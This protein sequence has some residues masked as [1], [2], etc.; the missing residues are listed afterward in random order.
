M[1]HL[2][3]FGTSHPLQ[4]GDLSVAPSAAQAFETEV[5]T[6]IRLHGIARVAEEMSQEGLEHHGVTE[7]IAARVARELNRE[8][9]HV[10]LTQAERNALGLGDGP[11]ATIRDPYNPSDSGQGFRA[12]TFVFE[13]EVRERVWMFRILN[14]KS[15]PV[16]FI[17]GAL[18]VGAIARIWA[19]LG[20]KCNIAHHDYAV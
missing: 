9:H 19:L 10:D 5:R 1:T 14:R 8:Y 2:V 16:L 3:V 20:L 13:S 12:G 15:S 18:H 6:L 17:C 4:C 7:T 11:A